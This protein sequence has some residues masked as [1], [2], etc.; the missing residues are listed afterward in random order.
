VECSIKLIK[1][2]SVK[3]LVSYFNL[4]LSHLFFIFLVRLKALESYIAYGY[5]T[6][7]SVEELI[8]RRAYTKTDGMKKPLNT[9]L[10]V[11]NLLGDKNILCLNDLV[12]EVYNLGPNL[13]DAVNILEPFDLSAPI[14]NY[15]KKV[16]QVKTDEKGFLNEKMEDFFKRLL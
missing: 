12:H 8:H 1:T 9:N 3:T 15:E 13:Q 7:K 14:G 5:I 4:F 10:V 16:L 2:A 6:L 11:E